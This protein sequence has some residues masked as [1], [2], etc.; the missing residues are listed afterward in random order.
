MIWR[1]RYEV[2]E[3]DDDE[4]TC[5]CSAVP[6]V[7]SES[8]IARGVRLGSPA[9]GEV[10]RAVTAPVG[11][12][13][14]AKTRT[15]EIPSSRVA[16]SGSYTT[17]TAAEKVNGCRWQIIIMVSIS[18]FSVCCLSKAVSLQAYLVRVLSMI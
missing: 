3:C 1:P 11:D 10:C 4:H 2:N 18:A 13:H 14:R 6:V 12:V 9:H 15:P 17:H 7:V 5:C 16:I 8:I